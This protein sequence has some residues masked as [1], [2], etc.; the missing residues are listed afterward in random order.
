MKCKQIKVFPTKLFNNLGSFYLHYILIDTISIEQSIV[1]MFQL[2]IFVG[3]R[4]NVID[5][6]TAALDSVELTFKD[7]YL[8]RSDMWRLKNCLVGSCVYTNKKL[9][10][11]QKSVRCQVS[12]YMNH[13][14][15]N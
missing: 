1:S 5:P 14:K 3:V 15:S 10:F 7:Q 6:A 2:Q 4:V 12:N 11:C 13:N 8:G 9:E